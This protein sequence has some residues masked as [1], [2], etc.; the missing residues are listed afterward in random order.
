MSAEQSFSQPSLWLRL[1][2]FLS[3]TDVDEL[4]RSGRYDKMLVYAMVFR[5]LVT[6]VFT[7]LL[8][9]YG[10]SMFLDTQ[11]AIIS[12]VIFAMTLF[13][14]DQAIVGSDW[15]LKNPFKKNMSVRMIMGLVPRILY[16]LIIAFGLATLAEISLQSDAIDEQIQKQV[17]ENNREYFTRLQSYDV[18]LEA[19]IA[20]TKEKIQ[21]TILQIKSLRDQQDSLS[22]TDQSHDSETI[23]NSLELQESV[24]SELNI[25]RSSV[26]KELEVLNKQLVETR[27]Q[28]EYWFNEAL[29]ERTGQDGRAPTEGPKYKRAVSTYED[30]AK[31]IP[32]IQNNIVDTNVKLE[33]I[34][35]EIQK[36]TQD[37]NQLKRIENAIL[38]KNTLMIKQDED[39]INLQKQLSLSQQ[40]LEKQVDEKHVQIDVYKEK[41][42]ADGLFYEQKKGVLS[43]YLALKELHSDPVLG[44][45]S[46]LFSHLLKIF[47][48]AIELMPVIIKIFFS[49]FSFYSLRMYRKMQVALISEKLKLQKIQ[50]DYIEESNQLNMGDNDSRKGRIWA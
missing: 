18:E 49:P 31:Q 35:K 4:S 21:D 29:L 5:Q 1:M 33:N 11:A 23:V 3:L 28:Y 15:A 50:K 48:M 30:L 10:V 2:S 26:T 17:M 43:R 7:C 6:F 13:F 22:A 45:A 36:E 16:S 46:M 8:F 24:I 12:G 19:G 32:I 39:M 14:L 20:V 42:A 25:S 27:K 44:Q 38:G 40:E 37:F 47:F 9:I 41:L 34:D